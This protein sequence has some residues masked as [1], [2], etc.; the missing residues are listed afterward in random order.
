MAKPKSGDK[1]SFTK[2]N[3]SVFVCCVGLEYA[4]SI[5]KTN[6]NTSHGKLQRTIHKDK[7]SA[8]RDNKARYT[9]PGLAIEINAQAHN[10]LKVNTHPSRMLN[11]HR[12]CALNAQLSLILEG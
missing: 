3:T 9:K 11:S 2:R 6:F 12:S 7:A 1:S 4:T 10:R 8:N 5:C